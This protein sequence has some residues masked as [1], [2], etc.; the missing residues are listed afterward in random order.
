MHFKDAFGKSVTMTIIQNGF[1]KCGIYPFDRNAIDKSRLMPSNNNKSLESTIASVSASSKDSTNE[2]TLADVEFQVDQ[3]Q[4]SIKQ[5]TPVKQSKKH[6]LVTNRLISQDF[7]DIL[8]VPHVDNTKSNIKTHRYTTKARVLTAASHQQLIKEKDEERARKE[9]ARIDR[10]LKR[11]A[12]KN[13]RSTT[14]RK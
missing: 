1:R 6:P 2:S 3:S 14:P 5:S 10:E 4:D 9:K 7:V 12:E 8:M 11:T 13:K